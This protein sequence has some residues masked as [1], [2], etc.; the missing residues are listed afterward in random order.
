MVA[1]SFS[2]CHNVKVREVSLPHFLMRTSDE[3]VT[4]KNLESVQVFSIYSFQNCH[5]RKEL[6]AINDVIVFLN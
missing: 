6:L 5:E 4:K 1:A 3:N 2:L